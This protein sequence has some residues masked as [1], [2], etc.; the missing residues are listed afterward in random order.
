[1]RLGARAWLVLHL[2]GTL[3]ALRLSD[4]LAI[5]RP[6]L[7]TGAIAGAGVGLLVETLVASILSAPTLMEEGRLTVWRYVVMTLR[8]PGTADLAG[9]TAVFLAWILLSQGSP[10]SGFKL[11]W[12]VCAFLVARLYAR[13]MAYRARRR[14]KADGL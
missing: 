8:L 11:A 2:S 7:L 10:L 12:L 13:P 3:V 14:L 9:S 6:S 5:E 1:L 4:F